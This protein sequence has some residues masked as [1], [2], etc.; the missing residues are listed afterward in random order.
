MKF[1]RLYHKWR[2]ALRIYAI[3]TASRHFQ[4]GEG[5]SRGL[6]RD[7]ENFADLH[8][9]L[10]SSQPAQPV[11]YRTIDIMTFLLSRFGRWLSFEM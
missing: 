4:P 9:Q 6:P 1:S 5:S 8:F 2:E 7:C 11:P 3:E 10:S